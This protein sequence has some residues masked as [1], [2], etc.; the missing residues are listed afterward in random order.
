M[1]AVM[2][3]GEETEYT[4]GAEVIVWMDK[5]GPYNNPHETYPYTKLGLCEVEADKGGNKG[6]L[7]IGEELE[8]HDFMEN[9]FLEIKFGRNVLETPTCNMVLTRE[10]AAA[11]SRAISDNYRYEMY[12]DDLPIWAFL[13]QPGSGAEALIEGS[14]G[15]HRPE[16]IYTHRD[17][18]LKKNDG[19]VISVDM[20]PGNPMPVVEGTL[21][22]F[23][24]SV[25]WE[26]TD[27]PY[28][29]R[30][31]K[32]LETNFFEHKVHWFSIVNSFMLCIFL[33][34]VVSIILMKTLRK[35]FT[36]YTMTEQE[37]LEN[38]DRA[39]D[40]SGWK[41]IHGDVFRRPPYLMQLSVLVSTGVHIAATIAG[42]LILAITNTYYRE[43]GTTRA[44]AVFMYVI[45]T[46]LAGYAGG[47]LYRQFGGKTW[48]KAMIYQV[49]FLPAVLCLMFMIVNTTAWIKG[50]TYAIPFK[51]I[52]IL[53]LAFL[54]VCVPLHVIGTLWGRRSAADRSFPCRVHHLK[55]PIPLK[56]RFFV[57]GLILGA[58]LVPFGC[59]FI[60]MYFVFSSLWSYNKIYYVYGFMLAIF[61]L[62][63]L[64]ARLLARK[65]Q[66]F[67]QHRWDLERRAREL[68]MYNN[69]QT[70]AA[71]SGAAAVFDRMEEEEAELQRLVNREMLLG[72]ERGKKDRSVK[73][74]ESHKERWQDSLRG[75]QRREQDDSK[76]IKSRLTAARN[77][78]LKERM[79]AA[80]EVSEGIQEFEDNL[81]AAPGTRGLVAGVGG[82]ERDI[83][84]DATRPATAAEFVRQLARRAD[85]LREESGVGSSAA[86]EKFVD[87][88]RN[89]KVA[90]N[91]ARERSDKWRR[92]II[93]AI[94][95]DEADRMTAHWRRRME[96]CAVNRNCE[97]EER[98]EKT[99]F[100]KMAAYEHYVVDNASLRRARID[101]HENER[102]E[103]LQRR[104]EAMAVEALRRLK[105]G[106]EE[107]KKQYRI[108]HRQSRAAR[109]NDACDVAERLLEQMLCLAC[110]AVDH[111]RITDSR[112]PLVEDETWKGWQLAFV[113]G[114]CLEERRSDDWGSFM[115]LGSIVKPPEIGEA[116]PFKFRQLKEHGE[117]LVAASDRMKAW[118]RETE[119]CDDL[120]DRVEVEEYLQASGEWTMPEEDEAAVIE[121]AKGMLV[122]RF[123][124][125]T[126]GDTSLNAV[127]SNSIDEE[128][129]GCYTNPWVSE[130][131]EY[132]CKVAR[133]AKLRRENAKSTP[134][135]GFRLLLS[136]KYLAGKK[137]LLSGLKERYPGVT[138]IDMDAVVS[139]C[140]ALANKVGDASPTALRG[141]G[142]KA[143][144]EL[145]GGGA[146]S[147]DTYIA[148]I[149]AKLDQQ[150][151]GGSVEEECGAGTGRPGWVIVG[152]PNDECQLA[153]LSRRLA[154][155][156]PSDHLDLG[157]P[158]LDRVLS[159]AGCTWAYG[160]SSDTKTD[161]GFDLRVVLDVPN[162]ELSRRALGRLQDKESGV[163]F[164][165][166][167]DPPPIVS[168]IV[169]KA[170]PEATAV[171]ESL[172][173]SP[174]SPLG[175]PRLPL[176]ATQEN[177]IATVSSKDSNSSPRKTKCHISLGRTVEYEDP[178]YPTSML[179]HLYHAFDEREEQLS[180][181]FDDLGCPTLRIACRTPDEALSSLL[182]ALEASRLLQP[183]R[184]ATTSNDNSEVAESAPVSFSMV[185]S[186]KHCDVCSILFLA[187]QWELAVTGMG[188]MDEQYRQTFRWF[189]RCR[190]SIQRTV[191]D[192]RQVTCGLTGDSHVE[193]FIAEFNA[194][195]DEYSDMCRENEETKDE[196]HLRVDELCQK[197]VTEFIQKKIQATRDLRQ[198]II[199][200]NVAET[201]LLALAAAIQSLFRAEYTR[202]YSACRLL[203]D[204]YSLLLPS[205]HGGPVLHEEVPEELIQ[206]IDVL[207]VDQETVDAN[208]EKY[209]AYMAATAEA[210]DEK[211]E[212]PELVWSASQ[213]RKAGG[214][215]FIEPD[216]EADP[217]VEGEWI[218]PFI[219]NLIETVR[220]AS[221]SPPGRLTQWK[222]PSKPPEPVTDPK[223]AATTKGG[224]K[225]KSE[226]PPEPVD[227]QPP[228]DAFVDYQ[229]ALLQE[230]VLLAK[231]LVVLEKWAKRTM[232]SANEE[233]EGVFALT[234]D[235]INLREHAESDT[236]YEFGKV[237]KRHIEIEGTTPRVLHHYTLEQTCVIAHENV[238][239]EAPRSEPNN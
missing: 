45:T 8:G 97:A 19:Q 13:G 149:V 147:D 200:S 123:G 157:D 191:S 188:G 49:F 110:C 67:E 12:I 179:P 3:L 96:E 138:I 230:K 50:L 183:L 164:H 89:S 111:R 186:L 20:I 103:V 194:F 153:M 134:T 86:G 73:W 28:A 35:D 39:G 220:A 32:Y 205:E 170:S 90:G 189:R 52:V 235:W 56:H 24:Y 44:S 80:R 59:V 113:E 154:G 6:D 181:T 199:A 18:H 36:K 66:K 156:V 206:K 70:A 116:D 40:D 5:V 168:E 202:F 217:P 228:P 108:L 172:G 180:R 117:V 31:D 177:F 29:S 57:P 213:I 76:Y 47:R 231:K 239:L 14:G 121:G 105:L 118:G 237:M 216:R 22:Q 127:L 187:E 204:A 161:C 174:A 175:Q 119:D 15:S 141:C 102:E 77:S 139:E 142:Q 158:I 2:S 130:I 38:F 229:K 65:L 30:F 48:K 210:N 124:E 41:Q 136:G 42:V 193:T 218:F 226:P 159:F 101:L 215:R 93:V 10:K 79:S 223:A 196:L 37:E 17:F 83:S 128:G 114:L 201:I 68:D 55:R 233:L 106:I 165:I 221:E 167:T 133:P 227:V 11:L 131:V 163:V 155:V 211:V 195:T 225:G 4:D 232:A 162:E 26:N 53:L 92:R 46:I 198:Q 63:T 25:E 43:R 1:T 129:I 9:Q 85:R 207:S 182:L 94:G 208:R 16:V 184:E 151:G 135:S 192:I 176:E 171:I 190:Q 219:D 152:F 58:G 78:A 21:L 81:V 125:V 75:R 51:T 23:T 214:F 145:A 173:G 150:L 144:E 197:L 234:E 115:P 143:L 122:E 203:R 107:H 126:D 74:E 169:R 212:A 7:S 137:T 209:E 82:K 88:M 140:M 224:K 62:L 34:A 185:E 69:E 99:V 160:S 33:I 109:N 222:D 91:A 148:M 98:L 87:E 95:E 84:E 236:V 120:I 60:E 71:C 132:V 54:A 166:Q 61:G 64:A 72:H 104:E 178:A 27:K 238:L 146:I 100:D 112:E